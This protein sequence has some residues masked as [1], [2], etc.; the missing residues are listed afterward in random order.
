MRI[1]HVDVPPGKSPTIGK[2]LHLCRWAM[3]GPEDEY[4]VIVVRDSQAARSVH[5]LGQPLGLE[6]EQVVEYARLDILNRTA[7]G[8]GRIIVA[9]DD[10]DVIL[11]RLLRCPHPIDLA[12]VSATIEAIPQL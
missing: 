7:R 5:A 2:S 9:L 12:T 11:Q 10:A 4:R 1:V 8:R 3:S 6:R